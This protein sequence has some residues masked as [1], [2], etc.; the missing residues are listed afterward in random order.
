MRNCRFS[1]TKLLGVSPQFTSHQ[2]E[3]AALF[4][5]FRLFGTLPITL[6]DGRNFAGADLELDR[7]TSGPSWLIQPRIAECVRETI[8]KGES[9]R[10]LYHVVAF[11]VMPNHVHLLIEPKSPAPKITQFIEGVSALRANELLL[12]TGH[13]FWQDESFDR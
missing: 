13:P 8:L 9:E 11:V 2:P 4:I 5:T 3:G 10:K 12:R 6:R 1:T 7:A